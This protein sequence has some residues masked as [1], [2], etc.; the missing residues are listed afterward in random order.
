MMVAVAPVLS[1]ALMGTTVPSL[2]LSLQWCLY[3]IVLVYFLEPLPVH[4][5]V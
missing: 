3:Y 5:L 4:V 1:N 2:F